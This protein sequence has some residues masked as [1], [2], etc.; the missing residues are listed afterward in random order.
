[1]AYMLRLERFIVLAA[2]LIS[3]RSTLGAADQYN[4]LYNSIFR[5]SNRQMAPDE[6][7]AALQQ[8]QDW[9]SSTPQWCSRQDTQTME[10]RKEAISFWL[11]AAEL[12]TSRCN[13]DIFRDMRSQLQS[14]QYKAE[15][16]AQLVPNPSKS[17]VLNLAIYSQKLVSE[18]VS[19]CS[20]LIKILYDHLQEAT[21][22]QYQDLDYLTRGVRDTNR[23]SPYQLGER[24][25]HFI[26]RKSNQ[27]TL[28]ELS[29][30]LDDVYLLRD[31][32][33]RYTPCANVLRVSEFHKR[34]IGMLTKTRQFRLR[35]FIYES[36]R[37]PNGED[38]IKNWL[39]K[40]AICAFIDH[41][42]IVFRVA[43]ESIVE[44]D[45]MI[46]T[47]AGGW[48]RS[49]ADNDDRYSL[50]FRHSADGVSYPYI[51][52]TLAILNS[53]RTGLLLHDLRR[54]DVAF[55]LEAAADHVSKCSGEDD[56]VLRLNLDFDRSRAEEAAMENP[57]VVARRIFNLETY[58]EVIRAKRLKYCE[59]NVGVFF[60]NKLERWRKNA[61][62]RALTNGYNHSEP[63]NPKEMGRRV[64]SLILKKEPGLDVNLLRGDIDRIKALYVA[65]STCV[66]LLSLVRAGRY[67]K[68]Y[69]LLIAPGN[70]QRTKKSLRICVDIISACRFIELSDEV[71]EHAAQWL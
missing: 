45:A 35:S 54:T 36:S 17:R 61:D 30:S 70:Y 10:A 15:R 6:I 9:V 4:D 59:H 56:E 52:A 51:K 66:D 57:P 40:V 48:T 13:E 20:P 47:L 37:T 43:I 16:W 67:I 50:I 5:Y 58:V 21:E 11:K 27:T 1:M 69:G 14:S 41:T 28:T 19:F 60:L 64:A 42:R 24:V 63:L 53:D 3:G 2:L 34:L 33:Q 8:L 65:N 22:H 49:I 31:I 44:A 71:F 32:Y 26:I 23:L 12:D 7:K 46:V 18:W 62:L 68:F 25:G 29:Q 39:D 55:W 38:N